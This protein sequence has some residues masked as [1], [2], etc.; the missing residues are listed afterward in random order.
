M[1]LER[2]IT[3]IKEPW[4]INLAQIIQY[5]VASVAGILAAIGAASPT[6]MSS[7]IGPVLI[8][9]V[10]SILAGGGAIGTFA[11]I[12]GMWVIERI[13]LIIIGIGWFA[14]LPAA[15]IYA[16]TKQSPAIWLVFILLIWALA[17]T[18]KRYR[19]IDWAYLD[20]T[21]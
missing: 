4:Q 8:I 13:A 9:V 16:I 12:R 1:S 2:A 18:F 5:A 10:G 15:S 14:L 7:T 19:R 3:L 21:R 11:V 17:D 20:P 6:F